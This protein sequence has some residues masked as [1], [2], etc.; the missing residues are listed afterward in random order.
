MNENNDY[1][2]QINRNRN[3]DHAFMVPPNEEIQRN[4]KYCLFS[5]KS[6]NNIFSQ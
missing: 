2:F 4:L 3:P 6:S 5:A 1:T